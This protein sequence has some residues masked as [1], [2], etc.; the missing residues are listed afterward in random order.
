MRI[1]TLLIEYPWLALVPTL[2]LAGAWW[3][4]R[5]R[6]TLIAA[7]LWAAY[8]VW[9]LMVGSDGPDADI[10]ID[11]LAI[12]PLLAVMTVVGLWAARPWRHP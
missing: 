6:V 9:E 5:R 4:R 7:C 10:R 1:S 12:Y 11:L 2:L 8:L 3:R